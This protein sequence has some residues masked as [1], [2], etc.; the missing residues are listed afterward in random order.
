MCCLHCNWRHITQG[1]SARIVLQR[2]AFTAQSW[3]YVTLARNVVEDCE[4]LE[5]YHEMY[6]EPKREPAERQ[7]ERGDLRI[8]I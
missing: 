7:G 8:R 6:H 4:L 2:A 5:A 3:I 1:E